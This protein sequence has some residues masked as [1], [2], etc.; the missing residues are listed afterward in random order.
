MQT[1]MSASRPSLSRHCVDLAMVSPLIQGFLVHLLQLD[2]P[3]QL[4]SDEDSDRDLLND[5]DDDD[6]NEEEEVADLNGLVVAEPQLICMT[7]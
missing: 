4:M 5:D 2:H 3:D 1:F 6:D 7:I